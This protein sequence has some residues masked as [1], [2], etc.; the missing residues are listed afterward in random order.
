MTAS[1]QAYG[2]DKTFFRFDGTHNSRRPTAF[3]NLVVSFLRSTLLGSSEHLVSPACRL[4]PDLSNEL[5]DPV[6]FSVD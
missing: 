1:E 3:Y 2:G 4:K 6:P 5:P